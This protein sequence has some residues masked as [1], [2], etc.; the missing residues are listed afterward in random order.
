MDV[1]ELMDEQVVYG[2]DVLREKALPTVSLFWRRTALRPTSAGALVPTAKQAESSELTLRLTRN[3]CMGP[4][5]L[6][7]AGG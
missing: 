3:I 4:L 6:R 5:S 1:L 7:P 2:L